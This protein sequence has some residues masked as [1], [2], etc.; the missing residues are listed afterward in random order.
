[1]SFVST[2]PSTH[3]QLIEEYHAQYDADV[4]SGSIQP[5][6]YPWGTFGAGLVIL[7][8]LIPHRHSQILKFLRFPVWAL[9]A[10]FSI[11]TVRNCRARTMASGFGVGLISAWSVLWTATL[12][13]V[14]DAQTDFRRI[15]RTEGSMGTIFQGG[16]MHEES[17]AV[18]SGVDSGVSEKAGENGSTSLHSKQPPLR[19]RRIH[20]DGTVSRQDSGAGVAPSR[21]KG[22]YAWQSYPLSP[23]VERLDWVAD[24]FC[25]FRGMGWSW[26]IS[27]LPQPPRWVQ[28]ELRENSGTE[29]SGA[30]DH[31]GYDGTKRYHT[32]RE[33]MRA[34][35]PAFLLWYVMLDVLKTIMVRDPYFWGVMDRPPPSWL[36]LIVQH[37]QILVKIYRLVVSLGMIYTALQEIFVLAPL[38][39]AGILGTRT[40]GARGEPWM[41][42]DC[43]GGFGNVL[44]KGLAGWW[45]GWWHQTFRF[46]FESPSNLV[47]QKFN[48]N[49]K[50]VPVKIFQLHVAFLLSG[51]L[52]ACGSYTQPGKTYPL[53]GPFTFFALQPFGIMAQIST[54]K[55][56]DR[57]GITA[58][59]PKIVRQAVNFVYVHVWF[60]HTAPLLVDDFARGGLWLF[61]PIPFSL[62]RGM[63][64]GEKGSVWFCWRG[65]W[66][67]W[68]SGQHWWQSGFAL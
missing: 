35:I 31:I 18:A 6:V 57:I 30:D 65:A 43:W 23:F 48:L 51:F 21:R 47:V 22:S 25:N 9:N 11:W 63:G 68:Y 67:Y 27:G 15:E 17:R 20:R 37:S 26:R 19:E 5:F 36:P 60:Y 24:V 56:L 44:D 50:S 3:T 7:Y 14:Y 34:K 29:V 52:H 53:T 54:S 49:K 61:E 62:L 13:V 10:W 59:T 41:Y 28:E 40:I 45:G 4:Q 58:R 2:F 42:P 39:F 32:L 1:M 38:F 66:A 16:D 64:L 55:A 12:L 46:A 8:L 33:L